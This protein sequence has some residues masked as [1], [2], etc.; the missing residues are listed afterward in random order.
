VGNLAGYDWAGVG[1]TLSAELVLGTLAGS[2]GV[3][4]PEAKSTRSA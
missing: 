3:L 4:R 2:G 1:E